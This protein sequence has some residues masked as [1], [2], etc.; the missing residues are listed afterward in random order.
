MRA[1]EASNAAGLGTP[2]ARWAISFAWLTGVAHGLIVYPEL[3]W[4]PATLLGYAFVLAGV[5]LVTI[6]SPHPL[7]RSQLRW[8]FTCVTSA[9][10][11]ALVSF[12]LLGENWLFN[13]SSYMFALSIPRGNV[14]VGMA[15]CLLF[16]TGGGAWALAHGV[17]S[18]VL[19]TFLT[20]P[21]AALLMGLVWRLVLVHVVRQERLQGAAVREARLHQSTDEELTKDIRNDLDQIAVD[22]VPLLSRIANGDVIDEE[23]IYELQV[24]EGAVRDRIRS[25]NLQHPRVREEIATARRRGTLV[26]LLGESDSTQPL[27]NEEMADQ[28]VAALKDTSCTEVTIRALPGQPALSLLLVRE[29]GTERIVLANHL[30]EERGTEPTA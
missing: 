29:S 28:L 5:L 22:V 16:I 7:A 14:R 11:I 9:G 27:V 20:L 4:H 18:E 17:T 1:V 3:A 25:R 12:P 2:A 6:R 30:L 21:T 19:L 23:L 10:A 13:F 8:F 26:L 15:G 24:R